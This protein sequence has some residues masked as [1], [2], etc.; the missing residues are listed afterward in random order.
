MESGWVNFVQKNRVKLKDAKKYKNGNNKHVK[1]VKQEETFNSWKNY[2]ILKILEQIS[3]IE[4]TRLWYKG[5]KFV[6]LVSTFSFNL[7]R[8]HKLELFFLSVEIFFFTSLIVDVGSYTC[9]AEGNVLIQGRGNYFVL[10]F[11]GIFNVCLMLIMLLLLKL[12]YFLYG[13]SKLALWFSLNFKKNIFSVKIK[14]NFSFRK[15][16]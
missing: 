1:E 12:D 15:A 10:E 7:G 13:K 4:M 2:W 11:V 8:R 16:H 5:R 9:G 14:L 3:V 6:V